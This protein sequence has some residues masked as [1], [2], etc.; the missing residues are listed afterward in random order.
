LLS[1]S[2]IL[3]ELYQVSTS[4]NIVII[5]IQFVNQLLTESQIVF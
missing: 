1:E 4:V 5:R 2:Q 3:F